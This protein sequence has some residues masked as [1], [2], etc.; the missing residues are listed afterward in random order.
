MPDLY[1]PPSNIAFRLRNCSSNYVLYSR[2]ANEPLFYHYG[3]AIADDQ[4]WYLIPGTGKYDGYYLIKSKCTGKVIFSRNS[5]DPKVSHVE[6]DGKWDDNYFK[7]EA[8]SGEHKTHFRLRN[9]SSDT[10]IFSRTTA[11]PYLANC[12][13]SYGPCDDQ[14]FRFE[15]EDMDVDRIEYKIDK[16]QILSSVPEAMG[17]DSL[18]NTSTVNQS[19]EF[20]FSK[21]KTLSSSFDYTLGFSITVGRSVKVAVPE[22]ADAELK[23]DYTNSHEFKWGST[24]TE[25]VTFDAKVP[26]VAPP[27][28]KVTA[29][30]T[31]TCCNIEVPYTIYL[32]SVA[33]GATVTSQGIYRGVTYWNI[34]SSITQQNI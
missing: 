27:S 1:I 19:V 34:E 29:T 15:F 22:V 3:G 24:T 10:V 32:K 5:P 13:A 7:I 25:S 21:T 33:T 30:A 28:T 31:I 18:R 9:F 11:E 12:A 8:G 17:S 20:D 6:G 2:K 16:G 14:Y 26:V 23:V 4:F